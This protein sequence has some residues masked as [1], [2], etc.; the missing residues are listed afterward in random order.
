M[1]MTPV[2]DSDLAGVTGQAG[3]NINADLL[4]NVNIGTMA[5]GDSTGIDRWNNVVDTTDSAGYIG[6]TNFSLQGLHIIAREGETYNGY[7]E[8]TDLAP[9]TIDVATGTKGGLTT[10]FVRFG[11]GSLKISTGAMDFGVWLGSSG[12]SL[13]TTA[14]QKLGDVYI[15]GIAMYIQPGS[16][17]DI[18]NNRGAGT[19]GVTMDLN[20]TIDRFEMSTISWGDSDG[21]TATQNGTGANGWI[22]GTGVATGAGFVGLDNLQ[23][24]VITITGTVTI[25]VGSIT[26]TG[27]YALTTKFHTGAVNQGVVHI[28]FG[29]T[30]SVFGI[31]VAGPITANVKLS[32]AKTLVDSGAASTLG[33]IYISG[34]NVD[35]AGPSWVDIW[36]H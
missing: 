4:M 13:G 8:A 5:W 1:A 32:N 16:Y 26:G 34:F 2:T 25:D 27:K 22:S 15:N 3:V 28:G 18:Y 12:A 6:I 23:V 10:T 14:A 24:G 33:D 36:A 17:V 30:G 20:V 7:N 35:I 19:S 11:L 9:I 29:G 31:H 21:L